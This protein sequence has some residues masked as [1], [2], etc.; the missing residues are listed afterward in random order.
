MKEKNTVGEIRLIQLLQLSALKEIE[1][2]CSEL[3]I[4]YFA[5]AGTL[6]GSFRHDGFIPWDTDADIA[7]FRKD[8]S[9][10]VK[11][12]NEVINQGFSIQSDYNDDKNRTCFARVRIKGTEFNERNNIKNEEFSGFYVDV[13]PIDPISRLP[14]YWLLFKHKIFKL[15]VRVKAYR[16]GKVM[17]S[18]KLRSVIGFILNTSFF[19][20]SNKRLRRFLEDFPKT[21]S[22][23]KSYF[24]TN[25]NSKYGLI[26]QTMPKSE[27][28]VSR[29]RLFDGIFIRIPDQPE[30]WLKRI[31]GDYNRIP[32]HP[33]I[34]L[35]ALLPNY[36]VS[37]GKYTHLLNMSE[38]DVRNILEL[39]VK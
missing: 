23:E 7:M 22:F 34:T 11:K 4:D 16:A 39:P 1:R 32:N 18:T 30:S 9:M 21:N 17:S 5:I 31:Y 37:F 19:F 13:F 10:F 15:L 3:G 27:Y 24:V 25:Y 8:Y 12:G 2:V 6:L 20:L 28:G 26:K 35:E 14:N 29:R 38:C 36:E 33:P